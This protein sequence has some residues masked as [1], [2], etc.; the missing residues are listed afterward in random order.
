[1]KLLICTQA[2]DTN[3]PI[4]G[5][6]HGW[7]LEFS[8]HCEEVHVICLQKGNYTLPENVF[9]YSLGKE[10][11]EGRLHYLLRFFSLI[12]KLRNRY[13][14]VFVHMNQIYAILG[15]PIWKLTGKKVGLWYMHK[16]VTLSLKIAEKLVSVIFTGSPESFRLPSKR[17]FVT[18]H[19]IDTDRF[20]RQDVQKDI[21]LIT[22]GR[23]SR[24]KNIEAVIDVLA[25]VR[26][27]FSTITLTIVGGAVSEDEKAYEVELKQYVSYKNLNDAVV[28]VGSITQAE[29]PLYLS[30]AKVFVHTAQ[31]GSLDKAT[32]EPLAIGLPLISTAEGASSLP[33]GPWHAKDHNACVEQVI[34]VLET[35]TKEQTA[36]LQDYVQKEHSMKAL[37]PKI[38]SKY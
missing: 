32:L 4:L 10:N 25:D 17:V 31:N 37:I 21:D 34:T 36:F 7:V 13:D 33:L 22:V 15:F 20:V 19:G 14:N 16:S 23:L 30:R 9:V 3:H 26:K 11:K 6:F 8:K 38:L 27:K 28:F 24:S 2:L 18:G 12:W 5:F 35:D 1:M 29:L